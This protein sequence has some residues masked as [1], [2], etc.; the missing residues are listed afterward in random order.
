MTTVT[1]RVDFAFKGNRKRAIRD[2]A[3]AQQQAIGRIPRISKLMALAIRFDGLLRKGVVP[4]Q[5]E[6]AAL[7]RVT[8]PRMTQIMNLLHLA[9]DIQEELLFLPA[10]RD[11]RDPITERHLRPVSCLHVWTEQRTAWQLL[12]RNHSF[13]T[14][15]A[16][17]NSLSSDLA[18]R[19]EG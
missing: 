4:N 9:P 5:S 3:P 18:S 10:V 6:L 12:L 19:H 17:G 1:R 2:P 7:A 11:G 8:Q 16:S 15:A 13:Q 14:S